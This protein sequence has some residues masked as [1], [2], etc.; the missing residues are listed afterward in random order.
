MSKKV[1]YLAS[2]SP[3][4]KMI[5][6]QI[7]KELY[8]TIRYPNLALLKNAEQLERICSN[9]TPY[10]YVKRVALAKAK[11]S[12][13]L[14]SQEEGIGYPVLTG[15]TIVSSENRIILK[16]S[17]KNDVIET[18]S[19]LSNNKHKVITSIALAA[20]KKKAHAS[21]NYKQATTTTVVWFSK[22]PKYW[23]ADY[24]ETT[25]PFDKSGAYGIQ[26]KIA[27]FIKKISGS[28]SSVMG[29]PIHETYSLL[30]KNLL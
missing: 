20:P 4:R 9:E 13:K 14:I 16:P 15:D 22:I 25:E 11:Y 27:I 29:L 19:A 23:I 8:L 18:I 3:R 2:K 7:C 24:S 28:H 17:S 21:F 12:A 1:L 5:L 6:K 30:K 10:E 26:G